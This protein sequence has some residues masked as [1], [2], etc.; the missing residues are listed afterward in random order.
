MATFYPFDPEFRL[1]LHALSSL[2]TTS[3]AT[4]GGYRYLLVF[5][6]G[7]FEVERFPLSVSYT[8]L[9]LSPSLRERVGVIF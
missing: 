8:P 1:P 6:N 2:T 9:I 3:V 4:F 5:V 7:R